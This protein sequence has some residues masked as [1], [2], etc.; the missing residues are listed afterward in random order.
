MVEVAVQ[1]NGKVHDRLTPPADV[2]EDEAIE[3][4]LA[5]ARVQ[6]MLD[7]KEVRNARYVLGRLVSLVI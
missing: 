4:A 3:A 7:G 5:S 1:A 2:S 6:A